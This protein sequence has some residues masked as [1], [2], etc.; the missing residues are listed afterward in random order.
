MRRLAYTLMLA[1]II[2]FITA[3]GLATGTSSPTM[4][5]PA[6]AQ[7]GTTIVVTGTSP[8]GENGTTIRVGDDDSGIK[9][10]VKW[11]GN[12]FTITFTA[13][14]FNPENPENEIWIKVR[15]TS[16]NRTAEE[17]ITVHP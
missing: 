5:V 15:P 16:P 3:E 6:D 11:E 14:A 17:F 2:P 1:A 13:P 4:V 9:T 7:G 12:S 10:D 8:S